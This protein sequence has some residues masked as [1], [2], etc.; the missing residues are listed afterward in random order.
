MDGVPYFNDAQLLSAI[1]EKGRC[2][3]VEKLDIEETWKRFLEF[4]DVRGSV[5]LT[6]YDMQYQLVTEASSKGWVQDVKR[7]TISERWLCPI[8]YTS[9]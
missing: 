7:C 8:G 4:W 1:L 5:F 3:K 2:I 9:S 6:A